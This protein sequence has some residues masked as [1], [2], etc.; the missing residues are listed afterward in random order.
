M[1]NMDNNLT[2]AQR[3]WKRRRARWA[4]WHAS[5]AR[6][7]SQHVIGDRR[8]NRMTWEQAVNSGNEE[9]FLKREGEGD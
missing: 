7:R 3:V 6:A 5:Q 4:N 9:S 2:P 1:K 8:F